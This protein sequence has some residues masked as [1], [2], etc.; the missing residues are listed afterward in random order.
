MRTVSSC[1]FCRSRKKRCIPS[2]AGVACRLCTFK[3]LECDAPTTVHKSPDIPRPL[4]RIAPLSQSSV[5]ASEAEDVSQIVDNTLRDE[6]LSEELVDIYFRVIHYKQH[7]L[8]H[9]SSFVRDQQNGLVARYILLAV[10]ALSARFS[11]NPALDQVAPWSRGK[12]FLR[13]AIKS[14]NDRTK[15]ISI[16]ALQGCI[17]LA[18]TAFVEGDVDQDALLSCQAV[19]MTQALQLPTVLSSDRLMRE[20]EINLYWQVWMMDCWT[21]VRSQLPQQLGNDPTFPRPIREDIFDGLLEDQI[22][23]ESRETSLWTFILPLTQW[24]AQAVKLNYDI[25]HEPAFEFRIRNLV[26]DLARK[27]DHWVQS[28]PPTL[29]N[30]SENWSSYSDRGYGRPFAVMHIIYHHTSQLLFYQFLNK[31]VVSTD[32]AVVDE[33]ALEYAE[34]CKAHATA[35]SKLF[36][37]LNVAPDLDCLWS[38]VNSHLLVIASTI[39]LH[40]MLLGTGRPEA[41]EGKKLLEQNFIV[42]QELQKFWPSTELAFSRLQAFHNACQMTSISKTFNMDQWMANFL[43]RY[44]ISVE[45]RELDLEVNGGASGSNTTGDELMAIVF[46]SN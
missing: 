30:T 1:S 5:S 16:E 39:H 7:L 13:E 38:P 41:A 34:L 40:T 35:L 2:A 36:W 26:R 27:L 24:H 17:I 22:E 18:F 31:C 21:S 9:H 42:L 6:A 19:R 44:D 33:E 28:L 23:T 12:P 15:L 20:I 37:E 45:D 11:S 25:V 10:F 8:F 4:T 3:G 29:R 14:F 46:S 43:N 32:N